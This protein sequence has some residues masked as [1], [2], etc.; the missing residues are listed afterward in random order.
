MATPANGANAFTPRSGVGRTGPSSAWVAGRAFPVVADPPHPSE[1]PTAPAATIKLPSR[2]ISDLTTRSMLMDPVTSPSAALHRLAHPLSDRAE[3]SNGRSKIRAFKRWRARYVDERGRE[4]AKGFDRKVDAQIWIDKQTA[5]TCVPDTTAAAARP[6]SVTP[7][8]RT[9]RR[10]GD[11]LRFDM[12]HRRYSE[13][14]GQGS[15][16]DLGPRSVLPSKAKW[17]E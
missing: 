13:H 17:S 2:G 12:E 10:F 16:D 9:A 8:A 14:T 5:A 3:P 6:G 1:S 4:H 7:A 11:A 15:D